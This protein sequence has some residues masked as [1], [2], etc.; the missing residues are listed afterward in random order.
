MARSS[1]KEKI[2]DAA[3]ELLLRQ[4]YPGTTVDEIC[5]K[6]GVS[7][8]SFY[9]SFDSKEAM[10]LAALAAYYQSGAEKL[11][12]GPFMA[13]EDPVAKA[14]GFLTHTEAIAADHW[15]QGCLLATLAL[16]IGDGDSRIREEVRR[17]F[18]EFE[19]G[20]AAMFAPFASKDG[21][22]TAREIARHFLVVTEGAIVLARAHGDP[23]LIPEGFAPFRQYL[24]SLSA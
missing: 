7:K 18:E 13:L 10:G 22:P 24:K 2:V 16:D 3:L 15:R 21:G 14:E 20:L 19:E 11:M 9:H 8:G 17:L 23:G 12:T 6:A 4:G 1:A 5:A